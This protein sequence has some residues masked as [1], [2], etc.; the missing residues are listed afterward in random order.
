MPKINLDLGSDMHE[1]GCPAMPDKETSESKKFYPTFH[2]SGD[3]PLKL[4]PEGEMVV[5]FKKVSSEH[6]V[7]SDNKDHYSCTIEVREIV[8]V[9]GDGDEVEAPASNRSRDS[10]D[11]LDKLR[12]EKMKPKGEDY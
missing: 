11:A 3:K 4:P 2:Y 10:E 12:A 8:S 9:Y 5:R 7:D 1:M 6:R